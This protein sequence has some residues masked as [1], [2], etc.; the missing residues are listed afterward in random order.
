MSEWISAETPPEED[1]RYLALLDLSGTGCWIGEPW[2][3]EERY[4][5]KPRGGWSVHATEGNVVYWQY[6][7][8]LP[9][10]D[11]IRDKLRGTQWFLV[12][13]AE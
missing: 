4:Y 3:M 9:L 13:R 2:L 8:E 1:G 6:L 12:P 7:P 10:E 11:M 5:S